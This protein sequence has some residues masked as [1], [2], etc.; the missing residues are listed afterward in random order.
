MCYI[1][2]FLRKK[3]IS[4]PILNF[5]DVVMS[6]ENSKILLTLFVK[7]VV[8]QSLFGKPLQPLL[9]YWVF[10][11]GKSILIAA[12]LFF[13]L[14]CGLNTVFQLVFEPGSHYLD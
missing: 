3:Y 13:I 9:L 12:E 2:K 6:C 4:L 11:F 1:F 8:L 7:S 14:C 5:D 10:Q